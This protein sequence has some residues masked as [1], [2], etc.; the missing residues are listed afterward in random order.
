MFSGHMFPTSKRSLL[1]RVDVLTL[2]F[3]C[4][5]V[6]FA[7]WCLEACQPECLFSFDAMA[8]VV[9]GKCVLP[10]SGVSHLAQSVPEDAFSQICFFLAVTRVGELAP[11]SS[12]TMH[13]KRHATAHMTRAVR[14]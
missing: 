1:A 5:A 4:V 7:L 6:F 3:G 12:S 11:A 9:H 14:L 8:V 2:H 13:M 10:F